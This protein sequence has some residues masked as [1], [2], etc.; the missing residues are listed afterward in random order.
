MNFVMLRDR[1]TPK[2][3]G[4]VLK[5]DTGR[6]VAYTLEDTRRPLGEKVYGQTCIPPGRYKMIVSYSPRFKILL[7]LLLNV[8]GFTGIRIHGGNTPEHTEG[9]PLVGKRRGSAPDWIDTSA[10][11]VA[12]IIRLIDTSP[13]P[14]SFITIIEEPDALQA[15]FNR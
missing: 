1:F 3:T 14:E 7:P 2:S 6:F 10:P 12:D 5:T 13:L 4:G 8:P 11:A 9:C 15:H